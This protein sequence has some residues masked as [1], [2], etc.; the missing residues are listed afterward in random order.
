MFQQ[1]VGYL[2]QHPILLSVLALFVL[3]AGVGGWYVIANYIQVLLVTILC[4]GGFASGVLV[5]MRGIKLGMND[6]MAVGGFLVVI[7][8]IIFQQALKVAGRA[9]LKRGSG[10]PKPSATPTPATQPVKPA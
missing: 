8:P 6:L 10:Q 2:A 3:L 4:A 1:V 7:F 9:G 5:L